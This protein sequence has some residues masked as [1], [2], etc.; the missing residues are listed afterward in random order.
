[1]S[2]S[3]TAGLFGG[4]FG[5]GAV[6]IGD[7][8][9]LQAMLDT[10][11]ALARALERAGLARRRAPAPRSPRPRA[12]TVRRRPRSAGRRA[13]RQPGARSGPR[14]QRQPASRS[15][16]RPCI[17]APPAR[18]SSTPPLM[19]LARRA[20]EVIDADLAAAAGRRRCWPT[21]T[22]AR[23]WPAGRCSS[24]RCRSR[25]GWSRPGWLT[26]LRRGPA[27]AGPGPR[28]ATGHPVRRGGR[29]AGLARRRRDRLCRRCWPRSLA[30]AEPALPWHT[31]RLRIL[32]LAASLA[33]ACAALGKIA[34]DVTL[35]AQTEV[36]EVAEGERRPAPGRLVGDA[37]QAEP[38]R[39]GAHSRLRQ[40]RAWPARHPGCRGRARASARGRGVARR[41][42]AAV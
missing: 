17:A 29:H 32:Q 36:A 11:A 34:R 25:S 3:G 12:R 16:A 33:G 15:R 41:V 18:T 19:L 37:A 24:R 40:A 20:I 6:G 7:R 39:V 8:D 28:D 2:E 23:S 26:A 21:R 42:G 27:R 38:G 5:R 4:L 31:D 22:R 14:A 1:M 10:E 30:C 35:L 13:D 9:W